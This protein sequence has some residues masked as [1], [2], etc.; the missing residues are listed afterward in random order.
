MITFGACCINIQACG[1]GSLGFF[2]TPS[3]FLI[4]AICCQIVG[5]FGQGICSATVMATLSSYPGEEREKYIGWAFSAGGI[6]L[7]M[8]P[9]FAATFY[10]MGGISASFFAVSICYCCM[11][12]LIYRILRLADRLTPQRTTSILEEPPQKI[13]ISTLFSYRRFFFALI[14]YTNMLTT[15]M[16]IQP[17]ISLHIKEHGY[18]ADQTALIMGLTA[19]SFGLMSPFIYKITKCI[20]KRGALFIGLLCLSM[21]ILMLCNTTMIDVFATSTGVMQMGLMFIGVSAAMIM[22]PALPEMMDT[23]EQDIDFCA[24]YEQK[25][26][27]T[28]VSSV[29]VTFH[30]IGEAVGPMLNSILLS[31]YGFRRAH[32]LLACYIFVFALLYFAICGNFKMLIQSW[33][34]ENL[35]VSSNS[36]DDKEAETKSLITPAKNPKLTLETRSIELK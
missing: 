32:E 28:V 17:S 21:A 18:Q 12:I 13:P 4:C 34:S 7:I 14:G 35:N 16:F 8:G 6:G 9:V 25:D 29:F 31:T 3:S 1:L 19:F 5:G 30:S 36:A 26:I 33:D 23:I 27:E 24:T 10:Q 15:L 2:T 22:I 11:L 20:P